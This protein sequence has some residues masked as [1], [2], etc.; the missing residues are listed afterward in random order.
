[1]GQGN[2]DPPIS[3]LRTAGTCAKQ[4]N[5]RD[6]RFV[7]KKTTRTKNRQLFVGIYFS[8]FPFFHSIFFPPQLRRFAP[9]HM[10]SSPPCLFEKPH[11]RPRRNGGAKQSKATMETCEKREIKRERE[12]WKN[13]SIHSILVWF[14]GGG[15][16]CDSEAFCKT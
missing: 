2:P 9:F 1:M 3:G 6:D 5:T 4:R 13:S 12:R 7:R 15:G 16:T 8:T 11:Q 14:R 10:P